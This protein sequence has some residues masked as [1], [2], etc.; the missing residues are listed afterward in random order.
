MLAGH[1][2]DHGR[3]GR[4]IVE[5]RGVVAGDRLLEENPDPTEMEVRKA[6]AGHLCRCGTYT[7]IVKSIM[8]AAE[9]A[10]SQ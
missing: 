4:G 10:R 5:Q 9:I 2:R 3:L 6:I 8:R 7:R 1:F